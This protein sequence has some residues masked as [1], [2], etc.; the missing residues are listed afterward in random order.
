MTKMKKNR[1][2]HSSLEKLRRQAEKRLLESDAEFSKNDTL[3]NRTIFFVG[4]S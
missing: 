4:L 3:L 2:K 1:G